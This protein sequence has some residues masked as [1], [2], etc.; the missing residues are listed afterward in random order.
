ALLHEAV[1]VELTRSTATQVEEGVAVRK[2]DL[3]PGDLVFFRRRSTRHVGVYLGDGEFIHASSSNGV[4]V[5]RLDE[6]YYERHYWTAR[7]VVD[8]PRRF[9]LPGDLASQAP[10]RSNW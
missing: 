1:G 9:L 10:G 5:S 3:L 7:R 2:E 8:D 6:T 4:I